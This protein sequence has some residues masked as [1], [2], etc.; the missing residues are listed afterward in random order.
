MGWW[1]S[2]LVEF[3]MR[4]RGANPLERLDA[5]EALEE[6]SLLRLHAEECGPEG[7]GVFD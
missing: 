6:V 4:G 2:N 7:N 1:L 5:L 3:L